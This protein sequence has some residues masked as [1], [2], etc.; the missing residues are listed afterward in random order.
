MKNK[1]IVLIIILA[2]TALILLVIPNNV[3]AILQSNG[4]TIATKGLNAWILQI[5]K[6]QSTGGTL[7]I[8]R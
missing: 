6:M 5:R 1:S 4:D 8:I 3:N 7:R 2:V